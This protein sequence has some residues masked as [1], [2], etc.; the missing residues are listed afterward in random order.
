MTILLKIPQLKTINVKN[1]VFDYN[2]TIATSGQV[3][4]EIF[5][6]IIALTETFNVFIVTAD[7]FDTVR[8]RFDATP[9]E[10]YIIDHDN[11][12]DDKAKFIKTIGAE[13]TIALGNGN[14]D[15]QMLKESAIGISVLGDEG[16]SVKSF[17]ASDLIV[18]NIL[19][20]FEMIEEPKKLIATLRQ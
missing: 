15:R 18:K 10:V 12:T 8:K 14:N 4:P 2:G 16:L 1:I 11:G 17:N 19:D 13:Q 20:F 5:D 3:S 7:T 9:V 6:Q